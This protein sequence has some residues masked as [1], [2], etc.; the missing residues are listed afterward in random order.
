[1]GVN[2]FL[3]IAPSVTRKKE[4]NKKKS[5]V[6]NEKDIWLY[7]VVSVTQESK[8]AFAPITHACYYT[9]INLFLWYFTMKKEEGWCGK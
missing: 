7:V 5:R 6:C 1:M 2:G 3:I 4:I 8:C 9:R